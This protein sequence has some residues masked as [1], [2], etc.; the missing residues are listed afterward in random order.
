MSTDPSDRLGEGEAPSHLSAGFLVGGGRYTLLRQIARGGMGVVWLAHDERL[1]ESVALKFL[2][3]ALLNDATEL[4]RLRQET[5]KSRKLTH[6]NIIRIYDLYEAPAE[7]AFISMEYVNG[8]N[9]WELMTQQPGGVFAWADLKPL[10]KQLCDALAYAHDERVIHRDLKP[11]NLML[12]ENQRLKLADFGL[13]AVALQVD[14][15]DVERRFGGGTLTHMSPQQLEGQVAAVTDDIYSLGAT[16]YDLLCGQPPFYEGDIGHQL[17]HHAAPPLHD[18]L[19]ALQRPNDVPSEVAALIMACLAKDPSKRPQSASAVAEW[20]GLAAK[21]STP[22]PALASTIFSESKAGPPEEEPPKSGAWRW[23]AVAGGLACVG[24]FFWHNRPPASPPIIPIVPPP[25]NAVVVL[26]EAPLEPPH[27]NPPPIPPPRPATVAVTPTLLDPSFD[28]GPGPDGEIRDLA[29]QA[30][31]GILV[32]GRFSS[33]DGVPRRGLVRLRSNGKLDYQKADVYGAIDALAL[34]PDGHILIAGDFN[35]VNGIMRPR[36]ARLEANLALDPMFYTGEGPDGE[37]FSVVMDRN[38]IFLTGAFQHIGDANLSGVARL[39][40]EGRVDPTF[41]TGGGTDGPVLAAALVD[42]DKILIGGNFHNYH[43]TGRFYMCAILGSGKVS[44]IYRRHVR[45][46]PVRVI[47]L[48]PDGKILIAGEFEALHNTRFKGIARLNPSGT[49]DAG[50]NPGAGVDRTVETIAVQKDGKILIGGDF[51][52]VDGVPRDH[53]ARL[54]PD[55]SL[56]SA[57]DPRGFG[58]GV[59]KVL[60]QPDGRILVAGQFTSV[61]GVSRAKL[62]RLNP[63]VSTK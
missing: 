31:G 12:A 14:P 20:I 40:A 43:G 48:Q 59:R 51:T 35:A 52:S 10:V 50:F 15:A 42:K 18:R 4:A 61:E 26:N 34:Q 44:G 60:V 36:I 22:V 16:L 29:L 17:R 5:Q 63:Q 21:D 9:L 58:A 8:P 7:P 38:N 45:G 24:L 25:S 19:A 3:S 28:P 32:A 62:A 11:T 54:N 13:A 33:F 6:A 56:D 53:L 23:L 1:K 57:F 55:G 39:D 49:V 41:Q 30:D 37:V 46:G 2:S 27:S 47:V